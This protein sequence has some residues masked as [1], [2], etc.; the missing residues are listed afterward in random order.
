MKMTNNQ[1]IRG[2]FF[3]LLAFLALP[4][5]AQR[6]A[7]A[8]NLRTLDGKIRESPVFSQHF[9]GFALYDPESTSILYQKDAFKYY[10]PASN[11]KLF[12][13]YTALKVLGDSM[14]VLR[15][16]VRDQ[17]MYV[18]GTGNPLFLHPDF[19]ENRQGW[20]VLSQAKNL[21]LYS[22]DNY[23]DD[24]FGP[25]WSWADYQYA[26]QVEKSALPMYGNFVRFSRDSGQA[27]IQSS[28]AYFSQF[29]RPDP[30][31]GNGGYPRIFREEHG[32]WFYHNRAALTGAPFLREVPFDQSENI[33]CA[34][35]EDTLGVRVMPA[36]EIPG[37]LP[38]FST[39][40]APLPDTLLQ[41]FMQESDNFLAEQLL[42]MC[43]EKLFGHLNTEAVIEYAKAQLLTGLPDT[44]NWADGSGLSRYNL[45]TPR[46]IVALLDR[47]YKEIPK[48]RL[49]R[50]LAVG[51][52][53]GTIRSWY[54]G[55]PEPYVFAK[56][57]SLAN[58]H[59]LSGYLLTKKGK[60][61]IFSFMHNNF[62]GSSSQ[63]R[64]EMQKVLEWL[65]DTM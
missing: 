7:M 17:L 53:S 15:Y 48:E 31:Q 29:L 42:L 9:T 49:F 27:A 41:R 34:L 54:A 3:L 40:Y 32:T 36:G 20:E 25:G 37:P 64:A 50:I 52:Q 13:L 21:L 28:P 44:L 5:R 4:A 12:T 16:G 35:L 51:G 2:V 63:V 26:Y 60:T 43:S 58:Q 55:S 38:V 46:T 22:S 61:L 14:P 30:K 39:L 18:Q 23:R 59:C 10:T 47:M 57:G 56:T 1:L 45:F 6:G 11:T 8:R 33:V 65:R 19:Q 24:H 62:V